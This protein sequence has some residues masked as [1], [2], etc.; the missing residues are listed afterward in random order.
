MELKGLRMEH[1]G[2]LHGLFEEQARQ[3]PNQIA[4]IFAGQ[5]LSYKELNK[6]ANQFAHYL[7]RMGAK[8]DML[9]AI[10]LDRSTDFLVAILAVLKAG[11]AYIPLDPSYPEERLLLLLNEAAPSILISQSQWTEKFLRYCGKIILYDTEKFRPEC[12]DNPEGGRDAG[13]LAYVIYTSGS[14][15]SPKGVM[16]EHRGVVQYSLW[17]ANYCEC[18]PKEIIDFSSNPSFDFALTPS[19]VS[20]ALGLTVAICKDEVKKDPR[21]YLKYL[22]EQEINFIKL[23]PSYFQVLLA[24]V[25]NKL[26]SLPHLNKIMLGGERLLT[27]DCAA[28]LALYPNHILFNEY[29]P[30]E[31]SVA[32]CL[33]KLNKEKLSELGTN[34]PIGHVAPYVQHHILN[35]HKLPV[36]QGEIGELYLGGECLARGYL[37]NPQRTQEAFIQNPFNHEDKGRLYKTGDLCYE[38]PKE[39]IQC[40]GRIDHQIK[41]RGFRVEPA[42]IEDRLRKHPGLKTAAVVAIEGPRQEKTLIAYYVSVSNKTRPPSAELRHYLQRYLP[43]YMIPAAFVR[44]DELPLN[45][46]E[47]LDR[48]ALPSAELLPTQEP[49][50][51]Q[52][53]TEKMLAEIWSEEI[54]VKSIGIH[55]DFFDLGG[56]SLSAARIISTI[57]HTQG[58]KISLQQ[59]YQ[60]PTIAGLSKLLNKLHSVS[61]SEEVKI[62][63]QFYKEN[64]RLPLSDFQFTLWLSNTFE[65]KAKKLNICARRRIE[66]NLDIKKLNLAF[67]A[68]LK[69]HEALSYHLLILAPVQYLQKK[70]ALRVEEQNLNLLLPLERKL[71][72]EDSFRQLLDY[73]PWPKNHALI[74]ARLFHLGNNHT[75]LQ[76]C[77]S[78]FIA[79]DIS[80]EIVFSDL[81]K[82]Y[83]ALHNPSDILPRDTTYR[84]Y[85]F[86]ERSH[87]QQHI[88]RDL[89]FWQNY[90]K[91]TALFSFPP[92]H[93]VENMKQHKLPYSTYV[94]LPSDA[95]N[96]LQLFCLNHHI[97]LEEGL[98]GVLIIAL[99]N[100]CGYALNEKSAIAVNKVKS[101]R[102]NRQYDHS[103]GCFLT[104]QLVKLKIT[105]HST[106][107][108]VC[109]NLHESVMDTSTYQ[110]CSNAIKLS[111]LRIFQRRKII[112]HYLI[113][114]LAWIYTILFHSIKLNRKII[115]CCARLRPVRGCNFLLNINVQNNFLKQTNEND[116]LFGFAVKAI[117]DFQY[118]LMEINNVLDACFFRTSDKNKPFMVISANLQPHFRTSIAKEMLK[119]MQ[120]EILKKVVQKDE[121]SIFSRT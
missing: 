65:P 112:N 110:N 113:G 78:H 58:K 9:I 77:M 114:F 94:E 60:N 5:K 85:I 20:L 4:T 90:L 31:A 28:W 16:I 100:C 7:R 11:A 18:Y 47:K 59:F 68:V 73:H 71:I 51:P 54:A 88:D 102:D 29:G 6:K 84:D 23:T 89:A 91:D 82:F 24:E 70:I 79:D 10:A 107:A 22:K 21:R 104:L 14:T 40:V 99:R 13:N 26:V 57:N 80:P 8:P 111:S 33:Y 66:G 93:V 45:A 36:S 108:S 98:S 92:Q 41:I 42:E 25:K 96:N 12:N 2:T 121:S 69:K 48:F 1:S 39:G 3:R 46:N 105:R 50:S 56:H 97:S 43:D 27:A 38:L 116:Q 61:D 53:K 117:P 35:S 17:F 34:V 49:L 44:L 118:D 67:A 37:N 52:T 32:V 81:S 106:L 74:R 30:T 72:L 119:L 15:G 62:P 103:L 75:E 76:L 86:I 87:M 63:A 83:L 115:H 55:D 19:I 95:L 101:T 120:F 64:M 109:Q